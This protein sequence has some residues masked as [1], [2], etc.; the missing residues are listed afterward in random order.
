M[1][2]LAFTIIFFW[3]INRQYETFQLRGADLDRF[4]QAIWNTPR[5]RFLYTTIK[6]ESILGKHFSPYMAVLSPLLFI[7]ADSRILFLFQLL[8]I[9]ISGLILYKILE[10]KRPGLALIFL[11]A[12]Y[13]NPPL[14]QIALIELRRVTLAMPFLALMLYGLYRD[15]RGLMLIG[16]LF[17][18]LIKEDMGLIVAMV[19]LF[20]L[21]FKRDW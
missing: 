10:D 14:H 6:D 21:L 2:A 17:A 19:G 8:G 5:G 7:W 15:K 12:F 20:L 9:A 13:L 11:L 1:L 3:L 18:L 16:L 4:T